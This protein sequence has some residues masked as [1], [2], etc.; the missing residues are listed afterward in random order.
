VGRLIDSAL[1]PEG[2]LHDGGGYWC[3]RVCITAHLTQ[4]VG[5]LQSDLQAALAGSKLSQSWGF[6]RSI[7]GL[8]AI[9]ATILSSL[10]GEGDAR[11]QWRPVRVTSGMDAVSFARMAW[12]GCTK[13]APG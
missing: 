11:H 10:E 5:A 9:V 2:R 1:C 12:G 3:F 8:I 4:L 7:N 13:M 6:V